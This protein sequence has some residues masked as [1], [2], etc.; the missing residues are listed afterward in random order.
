MAQPDRPQQRRAPSGAALLL[1]LCLTLFGRAAQASMSV[2]PEDERAAHPIASVSMGPAAFAVMDVAPMPV[3]MDAMP[4]PALCYS[5]RVPSPHEVGGECREH[6]ATAWPAHVAPVL[7]AAYCDPG[8]RYAR[9][10]VRIFHC[11]WLD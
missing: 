6:E 7:D 2:L 10:P 3:A 8:G 5:A 1:Y 9:L 4:C 11:G